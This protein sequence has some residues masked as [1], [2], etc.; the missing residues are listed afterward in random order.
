M[1]IKHEIIEPNFTVR[2]FE[3]FI[4]KSYHWHQRMEFLY[5]E[6][7]YC[8]VNLPMKKYKV[9]TGD[10]IF[11]HSGEIHELSSDSKELQVKVFTFNPSLLQQLNTEFIYIKNHI[12]LDMQKSAKIN[13]VVKFLVEEIHDEYNKKST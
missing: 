3:N 7:G 1:D 10:I 12:T 5:V 4:G 13:Q 6:K 11:I 2:E 8:N 9:E